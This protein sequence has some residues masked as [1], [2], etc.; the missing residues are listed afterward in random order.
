MIDLSQ[1]TPSQWLVL[2]GLLGL[3]TGSFLNVVAHRLPIMMQRAWDQEMAE[4]QG[5]D[6]EPAPGLN[7]MLPKSHCPACKAPLRWWQNIPLLSFLVLKGRCG[8]CYAGIS[9][10]YPIVEFCTAMAFVGL[11]WIHP[12]GWVPVFMM[13]FVAA[14]IALAVIDLDTYLLPDDI[15]LPLMWAGLLLNLATGQVSLESAVIGAS[16]GYMILWMI[17]QGFK[18][19]TGK[20]GMGY[21]DFKLLAAIGAWLG[22]YSLFTVILFASVFGVFFGLLVQ[23]LRGKNR[24]EPFPFGPCLVLGALAWMAGLN[25]GNWI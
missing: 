24:N 16:A 2:A 25:L 12:P 20:E 22:A 1:L 11:A 13:G 21:G 7:L 19:A 6:I 18:F 14:L 9:W 4:I 3:C 23:K 17:Y 5:R 8:H 10:R 15:T